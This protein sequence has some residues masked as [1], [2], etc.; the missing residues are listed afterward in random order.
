MGHLSKDEQNDAINTFSHHKPNDFNF[1]TLTIEITKDVPKDDIVPRAIS[2]EGYS[3]PQ[4][5]KSQSRY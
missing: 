5:K 1:M 4:T 3:T 2:Q